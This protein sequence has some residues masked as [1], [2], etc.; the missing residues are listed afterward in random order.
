MCLGIEPRAAGWVVQTDPLSYVGHYLK[1]FLCRSSTN[2]AII[3]TIMQFQAWNY[4]LIILGP[5][6]IKANSHSVCVTH[7]SMDRQLHCGK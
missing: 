6:E 3:L 7:V 5:K 1:N 4:R 2:F